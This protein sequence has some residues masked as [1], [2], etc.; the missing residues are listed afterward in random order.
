[1]NGKLFIILIFV[2]NLFA[3]SV[4]VDKQNVIKGDSVSFSITASGG[5]VVFPDIKKID[6]NTI[7]AVSSSTNIVG[8]NGNYERT[9]TKTYIFTPMHSLTIPSYKVLVD[10]KAEY[11]QP[12]RINVLKD[13]KTDKSFKLEVNTSKTAIVGY[14]NKVIIKFYQKTNTKL[15]SVALE[16]PKG[17]FTLKQ[18]GK[19]KDYYEGIYHVVEIKYVIIPKKEGII[20]FD[21]RLKLGFA[22]QTVDAFGFITNS[23]RYKVLQKE[24]KIKAKKVYDGLIG[25]FNISLNVDKTKVNAN[26][27]VNATLIIE[28]DGDLSSLG[29]IKLDIPNVTVYDNKPII[30]DNKYI[31]KYVIVA[32]NNYTIPPLSLSFYSL[33]E[34]RVKTI[35]TKPINIIVRATHIQK[36]LIK[37]EVN[38]TIKTVEKIKYKIDYRFIAIAFILGGIFGFLISKIN[39]KK[40]KLPKNLYNSLLPYADN[41][42]IKEILHK[43]YNKQKLSKEDRSFIKEFLNENKRSY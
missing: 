4:N 33:K 2:I 7:E 40:D 5:N 13:L 25:D 1:M 8:V 9:L 6:G 37:K 34:K 27:P 28:G 31:E 30:K 26:T 24:I 19:E 42:K 43:L 32:D 23:M 38:T 17:D 35:S 39:L 20:D 21:V 14:P 12:I 36:P 22:T 3:V 10:G 16:M 15:N 18:I 11:T 41:P 29:N